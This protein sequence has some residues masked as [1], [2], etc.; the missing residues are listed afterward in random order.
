[1]SFFLLFPFCAALLLQAE[2]RE[3]SNIV[4]LKRIQIDSDEEVAV[5]HTL[6]SSIVDAAGAVADYHDVR[7]SSD[8][9]VLAAASTSTETA[10]GV[11]VVPG[12]GATPAPAPPAPETVPGSG[13]ASGPEG[14]AEALDAVPGSGAASGPEGAAEALNTVPG[15]GAVFEPVVGV[16]RCRGSR[17]STR[18]VPV[19]VPGSLFQTLCTVPD[20]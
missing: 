14:A 6:P 4:A 11:G 19:H 5:D 18:F 1:M 16:C 17:Y 3:T 8:E 15:Y 9:P 13:A 7:A 2:D 10:V 12:S 20:S